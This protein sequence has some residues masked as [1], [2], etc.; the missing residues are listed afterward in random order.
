MVA[1]ASWQVFRV[2]WQHDLAIITPAFAQRREQQHMIDGAANPAAACSRLCLCNTFWVQPWMLKQA[3]QFRG[4]GRP[5]EITHE[6]RGAAGIGQQRGHGRISL[7]A[8]Q[9]L[10]VG[11]VREVGAANAQWPAFPD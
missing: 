10:T 5:I 4:G 7:R 3:G 11:K 9:G 8:A 2:G 6:Q 1:R